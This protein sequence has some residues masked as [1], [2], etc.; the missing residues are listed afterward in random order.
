MIASLALWSLLTGCGTTTAPPVSE[1]KALKANWRG[2]GEACGPGLSRGEA[3]Q[4]LALGRAFMLN[5]QWPAGN[6]AYEYDWRAKSDSKDDN[7]V[8]QAGATWGMG[9]MLHDAP[10][11]AEVRDA[12]LKALD[13][14]DQ[15]AVDEAG[16][17][18][19]FYKGAEKGSTGMIALVALAHIELL[20]SGAELSPERRAKVQTDL[21]GLLATIRAQR[22]DDGGFFSYY[23]KNLT[24]YRKPNPYADGEAVLA[25]T[26][27]AKYT[28]HTERFDEVV[29]WVKKDYV[30]NVANARDKDPDSD[31]T[32]GY[33]Q[34]SSMTW[35][36]LANS[37]VAGKGPWEDWL[38]ELA[39][40]MID[41]HRTLKR[42]R[43]TSYAY[44]GIIPAYET[45]R[46]KGDPREAKFRCVIDQGMRKLT[47][48]QL[49]HPLAVSYVSKAD[50][51]DTRGRG[52]IQNIHNEPGLR[53]D[54]TQH[55][56]HA[57][58]LH[59]RYVAK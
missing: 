47:S 57:V 6:F 55:Q 28:G 29:G 15:Q 54:V 14:W 51:A 48:W 56:M 43:N 7:E 1:K 8:R 5:N 10:D 31:T 39:V 58:I 46:K 20:R 59:R 19:L 35:F 36:E 45:A 30:R 9:L 26:K 49:G 11:D 50:P 4:S 27:A 41:T 40:W 38:M 33:Y 37:D 21:T 18:Y 13:F 2:D 34:W 16:R 24:P 12:L 25:L 22:A 53:I 32:K 52:G 42:T 23:R 17:R 44:E 3:D